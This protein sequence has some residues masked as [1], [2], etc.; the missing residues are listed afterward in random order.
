[1]VSKM[2]KV[3]DKTGK[4]ACYFP[5]NVQSSSQNH[6]LTFYND[7][8]GEIY[9]INAKDHKGFKDYYCFYIDLSKIPDGEYIYEIDDTAKGLI[10]IGNIL[11]KETVYDVTEKNNKVV[12]YEE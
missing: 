5:K 7:F 3:I 2:L 11:P 1:M 8:G 9:S 6:T 12:Q 10:I 4:V